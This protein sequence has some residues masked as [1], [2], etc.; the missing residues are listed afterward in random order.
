MLTTA[1]ECLPSH[2]GNGTNVHTC[3]DQMSDTVSMVTAK[4]AILDVI[5]TRAQNNKKW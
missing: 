1:F 2:R 5:T 4:P 3:L